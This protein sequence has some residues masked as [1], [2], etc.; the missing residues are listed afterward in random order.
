MN[1]LV[2]MKSNQALTTSLKVADTFNKKHQHV[3][4]SGCCLHMWVDVIHP[5]SSSGR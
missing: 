3:Y 2:I 5:L 4:D 1:D